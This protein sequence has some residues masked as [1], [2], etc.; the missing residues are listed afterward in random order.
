MNGIM[1]PGCRTAV[2]YVVIYVHACCAR[3]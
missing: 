1:L 2:S 3:H